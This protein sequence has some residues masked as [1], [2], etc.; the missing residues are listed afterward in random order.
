MLILKTFQDKWH[1]T[2]N[3]TNVTIPKYFHLT[4]NHSG[5]LK[6]K[7][8]QTL[9]GGNILFNHFYSRTIPRAQ[10]VV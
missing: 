1:N 7:K 6:K 8:T 4:C 5:D 3:N 10:E 2:E 9:L